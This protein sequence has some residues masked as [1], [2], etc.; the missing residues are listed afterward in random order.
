MTEY[1]IKRW[2]AV[3]VGKSITK[4]PVI[5]VE[6]DTEFI[7]FIRSNNYAVICEING[8]DTIYDGKKIPG[9]VDKSSNIPNCRP[10]YFE[11]TGYYV[12]TLY[13]TWNGYPTPDKLGTVVF[14]GLIGKVTE[15]EYNEQKEKSKPSDEDEGEGEC[16]KSLNSSK[17][18]M[19]VI[20]ILLLIFFIVKKV[21][22][23]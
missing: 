18:V 12:I 10:N 16:K 21:G 19:G 2:D 14:K 13:G 9:V 4:F 20:A 11:K 3:M 23:G 1:A 15:V 17:I 6:P 7:E 5:Y 22:Y 8:T